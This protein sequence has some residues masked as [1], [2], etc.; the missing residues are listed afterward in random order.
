MASVNVGAVLPHS[1]YITWPHLAYTICLG[2]G[3]GLHWTLCRKLYLKGY[4]DSLT[5]YTK[6]NWWVPSSWTTVGPKTLCH[7]WSE[8]NGQKA[9]Q[10]RRSA[11]K[12][13]LLVYDT[14]CSDLIRYT[15]LSENTSTGKPF[16]L[17][18]KLLKSN[19]KQKVLSH[20]LYISLFPMSRVARLMCETD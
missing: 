8:R 10:S 7:N 20:R 13:L 19:V 6:V 17:F 9:M 16:T 3:M 1:G 18:C 11:L 12:R 15:Y 5:T 2:V 14:M 4:F